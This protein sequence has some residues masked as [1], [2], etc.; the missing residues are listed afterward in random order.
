LTAATTSDK[1]STD[2]APATL[3]RRQDV[4]YTLV[5]STPDP[6]IAPN[7]Y[8]DYDQQAA[9][10]AV[11]ADISSDPLPQKRSVP[12][13]DVNAP[14]S[15]YAKVA[16]PVNATI[17]APLNCNKADTFMGS[18]LFTSGPFDERLCAAACTA[19]TSYNLKHPPASGSAKTCQFYSTH[20]L[21]KDGASQGQY[22]SWS[23]LVLVSTTYHRL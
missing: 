21:R 11:V 22:W 12:S 20:V 9:I 6:V 1:L 7:N 17:N 4:D 18:K 14:P 10:N 2:H 5:D 15:G 16:V 19:Q 8:T 3:H 13:S 23:Y